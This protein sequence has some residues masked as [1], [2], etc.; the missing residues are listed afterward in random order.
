VKEKQINEKMEESL[1]TFE[2]SIK[3]VIESCKDTSHL[4]VKIVELG[5]FDDDSLMMTPEHSSVRQSLVR[6]DFENLSENQVM[7]KLFE[8]VE[9]EGNDEDFIAE[10]EK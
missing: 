4:G 10:A 3:G 5:S 2:Q 9:S 6:E 7:S 8:K 1:K